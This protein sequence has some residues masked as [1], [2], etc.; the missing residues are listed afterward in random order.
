[1]TNAVKF[2]DRGEVRVEGRATDTHLELAVRDTGIGIAHTDLPRLFQP[3]YQLDSGL[4]R[5]HE[6]SGLGLSICRKLLDKMGGSIRVTSAPGV[7]SRFEVSLPL[8]GVSV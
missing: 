8:G 3:F 5:R 4:A 2:T 7:G 6:G 1:L